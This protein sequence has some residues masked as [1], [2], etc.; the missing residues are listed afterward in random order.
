MLDSLERL[1]EGFDYGASWAERLGRSI[2][3]LLVKGALAMG[4]F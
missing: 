1:F 3:R 2:D 4:T